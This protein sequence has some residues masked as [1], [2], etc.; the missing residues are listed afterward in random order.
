MIT[1]KNATFQAGSFSLTKI[2]FTVPTGE[3]GVLMGETGCGKS[4]LVEGLCGLRP[5]TQGQ[6]LLGTQDVTRLVPAQRNIGYVPQDMALFPR[7]DVRQ[8]FAFPLTLRKW[9]PPKIQQRTE[10]LAEMLGIEHLL[11]RRIQGLSGGE[12][13]RVAIGRALAWRP[14][15]LLLDEPLSALDEKTSHE[16]CLMLKKV[17][18]ETGVTTLHVTHNHTEAQHLADR[19]LLFESGRIVCRKT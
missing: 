6:V 12:T 19:L 5:T 7:M 10:E 18:R 17:Q 4:T 9:S 3:Y 1:V 15:T 14:T 13:Q 16:I 11:D 8:H 2:D